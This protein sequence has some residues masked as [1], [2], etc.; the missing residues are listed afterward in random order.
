[1]VCFTTYVLSLFSAVAEPE[2]PMQ[3][4]GWGSAVVL[5]GLALLLIW[6]G[7]YP[8][9]LLHLLRATISELN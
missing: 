3:R 5:G 4:L 7:V 1:M 9:P 2:S 6:F 8:E